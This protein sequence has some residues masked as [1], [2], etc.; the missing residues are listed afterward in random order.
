[1]DYFISPPGE[2]SRSGVLDVGLKCTHSCK[3]CYYSFLDKTDNQ[4]SG[5]RKANFRSLSD[6]KNILIGLNYNGFKSVDIT[7]GEPT[8]HPDIVEIISF[9]ENNLNIRTRIITLGQFL[10]SK[11]NRFNENGLNL[12]QRLLEANIS[13]FLFSIHSYNE[14]EFHA[15]TGESLFKLSEACEFLMDKN[16]QFTTNTAIIKDNYKSLPG[17]AR[18]V[19]EKGSYMHNFI[20]MNTY[21][22][23][24]KGDRTISVQTKFKDIRPYLEEAV[25]ILNDNDITCNIRYMPLCAAGSLSKHI[26]GVTGVRYD[27]YEWMNAESHSQCFNVD[28]SKSLIPIQKGQADQNFTIFKANGNING[29]NIVAIRGSGDIK[30][31][32]EICARCPN[33]NNCDGIDPKYLSNHGISELTPLQFEARKDHVLLESRFKYMQ[34]H[35]MKNG[36]F[37]DILRVNKQVSGK[38]ALK[39]NPLV[40]VIIVNYN[41]RDFVLL[42]LI[43]ALSQSYPN[44]EVIIVD[45]NST[46]DSFEVLSNV[47]QVIEGKVALVSTP[48]FGQP[49]LSRNFGRTFAHG[50]LLCFLD[51]DDEIKPNYIAEAVKILQENPGI[52]IAYPDAIY[53]KDG[54]IRIMDYD[55]ATLVYANQL[56]YCAVMR[57]EVF[58]S[59]GGFRDNVKGVEDWDFWVAA[60]AKGFF[61]KRIPQAMLFYRQKQEGIFEKEVKENMQKKFAQIVINNR[62]IYND[63]LVKNAHMILGLEYKN[64]YWG[65]NVC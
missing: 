15:L 31:F 38:N 37:A 19:V 53:S 26:V 10:T 36:Q 56:H 32:P 1:M 22:E 63:N 35:I 61:G 33:A 4:F 3:F 6:I 52:Y 29:I 2:L 49:A 41:Y 20:Y 27:P 23:W 5:M 55:Y 13:N 45:D 8:L 48:G 43:S 9:A 58:D 57:K 18:F 47:P 28:Q 62:E 40:S 21:Y 65:K 24:N 17:I 14:K 30:V 44:V 50:E 12:L 25:S 60:G 54:Y 51:A 34:P 39:P 59:I 16:F 7:G 64:Q 46:D 42:S 11:S